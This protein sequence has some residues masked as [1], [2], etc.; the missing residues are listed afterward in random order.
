MHTAGGMSEEES[1]LNLQAL[2]DAFP[3]PPWS[4]TFS[5]GRALQSSTLKVCAY[6][7]NDYVVWACNCSTLCFVLLEGVSQ[8]CEAVRVY[9]GV[10]AGCDLCYTPSHHRNPRLLV[11]YRG[12]LH[13]RFAPPPVMMS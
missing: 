4:L 7:C 13:H 5:Y 12:R 1:T 9:E 2:N 3:N 11:C 6:M 10:W 8:P